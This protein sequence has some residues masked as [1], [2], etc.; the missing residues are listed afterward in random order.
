MPN[1]GNK[2]KSAAC[3]LRTKKCLSPLHRDAF[4]PPEATRKC[5]K[6]FKTVCES[7][8]KRKREGFQEKD[9]GSDAMKETVG[10]DKRSTV[11]K[12]PHALTHVSV[13]CGGREI[14][15]WRLPWLRWRRA[16]LAQICLAADPPAKT[17]RHVI[18]P[19]AGEGKWS[20][21]HQNA[22]NY[23]LLSV[24]LPVRPRCRP[25]CLSLTGVWPNDTILS[26]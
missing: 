18:A 7:S 23:F 6:N 9:T 8:E 12:R 25:V 15:G 19:G 4:S 11:L 21:W 24:T 26:S 2:N 5:K 10:E 16:P 1:M 20:E 22:Q 3:S 13:Q 17:P 14:N